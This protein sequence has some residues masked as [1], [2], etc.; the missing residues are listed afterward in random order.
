LL[1]GCGAAQPPIGAPGAMPQSRVIARQASRSGSW[2]LPE[3]KSE[4][5]LYVTN[6]YTVTEYSYPKGRHVG[7]LKHFLRP[8]GECVDPAGDVFIANGTA[9]V[10]EYPHGGDQKIGTLSMY[11]YQPQ[12]CAVDP[13][14]GNLA[15]TWDAGAARG[16][17]AVY[18]HASGTPTL[19][20]NGDMLFG[21]CGYDDAGNLFVDGEHY[22]GGFEFA[23]LPKKG[24]ALKTVSLDHAFEH[25]GPVQWDGKYVTVGDNEA[26][27]IY[28][29]Q[30]SGSRG[31]LKGTTT[32]GSAQYMSQWW[33]EGGK[34]VIGPRAIEP[35]VTWYWD[36]PAGG[37]PIKTLALKGLG[38][39]F[40]ATVS[41]AE[42]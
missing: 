19:Y 20:Q 17:L 22:S 39:P 15:V 41:K 27:V 5:L 3:A 6:A 7:T 40:G 12:S 34:R 14:D 2:M 11:G 23:E 21:F 10:F 30:I 36:Y 4:D 33:I 24:T 42:K 13:T 31:M 32:L 25:E 1:A 9:Q 16:Y 28:R 35:D 26:E 8:L 38:S 18:Q 29:F 37:S